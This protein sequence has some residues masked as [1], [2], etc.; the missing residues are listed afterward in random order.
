[1]EFSEQLEDYLKS[2][3]IKSFDYSKFG[4]I[5]RIGEEKAFKQFKREKLSPYYSMNA[6]RLDASIRL[7]AIEMLLNSMGPLKARIFN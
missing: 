6:H 3:D 7:R 4:V 5:K 1:P 2:K